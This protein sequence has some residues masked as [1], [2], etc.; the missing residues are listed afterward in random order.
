[1]E[2]FRLLATVLLTFS[3]SKIIIYDNNRW[4]QTFYTNCNWD[5]MLFNNLTLES[6]PLSSQKKEDKFVE[7]YGML[8][9]WWRHH[10]SY[11]IQIFLDCRS[12]W[13]QYSRIFK[14]LFPFLKQ[15]FLYLSRPYRMGYIP[16]AQ[17]KWRQ[18]TSGN[19]FALVTDSQVKSCCF[20][21]IHITRRITGFLD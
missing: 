7:F 1:M 4:Q 17:F 19:F 10:I 14:S 16:G 15:A 5:T 18:P 6:L 12:T 13:V 9:F 2:H 21:K 20:S 11:E 3:C 8:C